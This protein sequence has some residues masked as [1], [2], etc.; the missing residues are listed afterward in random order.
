VLMQLAADKGFNY[1][2]YVDNMV[3]YQKFVDICMVH[4]NGIRFLQHGVVVQS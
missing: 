3:V 4:Y 2:E 1:E